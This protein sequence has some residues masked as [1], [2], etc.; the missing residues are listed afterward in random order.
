MI[1]TGPKVPASSPRLLFASSEVAGAGGS[2]TAAFDLFRIALGAGY[3]AHFVTLLDDGDAAWSERVFGSQ[4]ANPGNVP[5]VYTVPVPLS[6]RAESPALERFIADFAPDVMCGFGHIASHRIKMAAPGI[7]TAFVT[8]SCRQAQDYV[9]SG[10]VRDAMELQQRLDDRTLIPR[11]VHRHE[12]ATV[13]ICDLVITHSQQTLDFMGAFY[14]G[15]TGKI[16]PTVISFA[17]WIGERAR[18]TANAAREFADRDIDVLFVASHWNR[19]EKNYRM[20][21]Y[22]S[23]TLPGSKIHVVGDVPFAV[24]DVTHHGFIANR[25]VL[26]ALMGRSRCVACPSLIDAAPGILYEAIA[27]GA[28]V[29]TTPNCGNAHLCAPDLLSESLD[30]IPFANRVRLA[31]N[32]SYARPSGPVTWRAFRELMSILDALARPIGGIRKR[33]VKTAGTLNPRLR[34]DDESAIAGMAR[35]TRAGD[36]LASHG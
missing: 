18:T 3:D 12:V 15:D 10:I 13:N 36:S 27:L 7:P 2:A 6:L 30:L 22:L 29:V 19:A 16:W 17:D 25:D 32:R 8:G 23:R 35:T 33:S 11:P 20:V 9:T 34:G 28:N 1:P 24:P 5:N 26:F 4:P 14:P 21:D 31:T